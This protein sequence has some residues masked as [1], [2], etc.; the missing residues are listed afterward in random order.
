MHFRQTPSQ[1]NGFFRS[2]G[3]C[4]SNTQPKEPP[5]SN[6]GKTNYPLFSQFFKYPRQTRRIYRNRRPRS[7]YGSR[8]SSSLLLHMCRFCGMHSIKLNDIIVHEQQCSFN[9]DVIKKA[10]QDKTTEIPVHVNSTT[11][12]NKANNSD[13]QSTDVHVKQVQ[14]NLSRPEKFTCRVN[15]PVTSTINIVVN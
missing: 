4:T 6:P 10:N 14:V 11:N 2:H 8:S 3:T 15:V 1:S 7:T 9:P 13:G 5:T 12:A